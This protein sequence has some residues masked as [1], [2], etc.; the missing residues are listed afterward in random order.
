MVP[1][2]YSTSTSAGSLMASR[3][4]AHGRPGASGLVIG[5]N[6]WADNAH[7]GAYSP[8]L[9]H[10]AFVRE[11][12]GDAL[13]TAGARAGRDQR[14]AGEPGRGRAGGLGFVFRDAR[15]GARL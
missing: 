7:P 3:S 8:T 12:R 1:P 6:R 13:P 11:V 4:L 10:A 5:R 9:R 2:V 14:R 15:V